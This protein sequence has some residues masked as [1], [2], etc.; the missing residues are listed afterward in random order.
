MAHIIIDAEHVEGVSR[1]ADGSVRIELADDS[2]R[3]RFSVEGE[4]DE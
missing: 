2:D 3:K 4:T 1:H